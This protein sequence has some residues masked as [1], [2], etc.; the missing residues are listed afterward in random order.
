MFFDALIRLPMLFPPRFSII[1]HFW[2][3]MLPHSQDMKEFAQLLESDEATVDDKIRLMMIACL[4]PK[5]KQDELEKLENIL[6][7]QGVDL[8][9]YLLVKKCP[10]FPV[11]EHR[12]PPLC[13][14]RSALPFPK[15]HF[16]SAP[17]TPQHA[18]GVFSE[19]NRPHGVFLVG[20][21]VSFRKGGRWRA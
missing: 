11:F 21:L 20:T 18:N 9:A 3:Q 19:R 7:A 4:Q 16:L 2:I 1:S 15:S 5:A 8:S 10:F 12:I 17:Q 6:K 14:S 13:I